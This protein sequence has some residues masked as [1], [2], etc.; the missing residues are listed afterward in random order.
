MGTERRLEG[1]DIVTSDHYQYV[2]V[3]EYSLH[4]TGRVIGQVC[5]KSIA[6]VGNDF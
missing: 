4:S 1:R 5:R 3:V 6:G 2:T